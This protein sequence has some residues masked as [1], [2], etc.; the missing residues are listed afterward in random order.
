MNLSRNFLDT[1]FVVAVLFDPFF[2]FL[3][4]L[5]LYTVTHTHTLKHSYPR[6]GIAR[7]HSHSPMKVRENGTD[8]LLH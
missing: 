5:L 1:V 8:G 6:E 2:F 3:S 4:L 7:C